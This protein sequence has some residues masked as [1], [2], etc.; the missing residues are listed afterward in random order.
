MLEKA[1]PRLYAVS[2]ESSIMDVKRMVV[3]KLRGIFESVPADDEQLNS[4]I[5]VHV[6][7]NLPLVQASK[8]YKAKPQCEFCGQKHMSKDDY[9]DLKIDDVE[10]N[11]SAETASNTT[12]A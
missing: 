2:N 11:S 3:E 1:C 6:K 5:E 4:V 8:Y 9:C 10:V 12:I 7:E